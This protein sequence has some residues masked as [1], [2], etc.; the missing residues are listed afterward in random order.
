[1]NLLPSPPKRQNSSYSSRSLN[2]SRSSF[3]TSC[4][5]SMQKS[6]LAKRKEKLYH[7][8]LIRE[9]NRIIGLNEI[10]KMHEKLIFSKP[11][12][13]L[14]AEKVLKR[15]RA[16][17]K[18]QKIVRGWL[19]RKFYEANFINISQKNTSKHVQDLCNNIPSLLLF[20]RN[21]LKAAKMIQKAYRYYKLKRKIAWLQNA[22][23]IV[24]KYNS[25]AQA[26][27]FL[28]RFLRVGANK[29]RIW[30]ERDEAYRQ[31]KLVCIRMNLARCSI[32]NY[33]IKNGKGL[34]DITFAYRMNRW[35][36]QGICLVQP[37]ESPSELGKRKRHK[38][39]SRVY[40]Q[41]YK[42][43]LSEKG[44]KYFEPSLISQ[45]PSS[46]LFEPTQASSSRTR[47]KFQS[48]HQ[49]TKSDFSIYSK[50]TRPCTPYK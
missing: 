44:S 8:Y 40:V 14:K 10:R 7:E 20:G 29:A 17:V 13:G 27:R 22:Y 35:A 46:R 33:L 47:F 50:P 3:S 15:N 36:L 49:R 4:N 11:N 37:K 16:A 19:V 38:M 23:E 45:R 25:K 12:P 18:I 28:R 5:N 26:K 1:M 32:K 41:A 6:L 48:I 34:A 42:P 2:I 30:K 9:K 31:L 39:N 24:V 43:V 21:C